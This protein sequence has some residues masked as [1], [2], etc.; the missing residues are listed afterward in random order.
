[1]I[2][3]VF[4][5]YKKSEIHQLFFIKLLVF[6]FFCLSQLIFVLSKYSVRAFLKPKG[7]YKWNMLKFMSIVYKPEVEFASKATHFGLPQTYLF[8]FSEMAG[9]SGDI[10]T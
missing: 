7:C 4:A 9:Y 1:M 5:A 8:F 6:Y 2:F 3:K 10:T